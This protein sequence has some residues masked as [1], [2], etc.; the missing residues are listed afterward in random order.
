MYALQIQ[1]ARVLHACRVCFWMGLMLL[2]LLLW[3]G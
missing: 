3:V 1:T 2:L